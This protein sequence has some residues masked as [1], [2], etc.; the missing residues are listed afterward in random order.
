MCW[1]MLFASASLLSQS[2]K[3]AG[4]GLAIRYLWT[5]YQFPLDQTWSYLDFTYGAEAEF[6]Q[7][8]GARIDLGFPIRA[9]SALF[10]RGKT[11]GFEKG[12]LTSA[13]IQVQFKTAPSGARWVWFGYTGAGINLE[14]WERA[15]MAIP[16]G[17]GLDIRLSKN[18]FISS[19]I[20]YRFSQGDF[21]DHVQAAF[22]F[23]FVPSQKDRL[24]TIRAK[25]RHFRS[26]RDGDGVEDALDAC[27]DREGLAAL[28]G[29]PDIDG[30]GIPDD[31]DECPAVAGSLYGCPDADADGIA[32]K[33]DRCPLEVGPPERQGCPAKDTDQDGVLDEDDICPSQPG[34]ARTKGCPDADDDGIADKD[35]QCPALAGLPETRGCPD[36]DSDGVPDK[37][38]QC[39]NTPG[40][41]SGTGCPS[42]EASEIALLQQA[43]HAIHFISGPVLR[44]KPESFKTLDQI[45]DLM[46]KYPDFE[47][48]IAAFTDNAGEAETNRELSVQQAKFCYE[49]LISRGIG[50][51]RLSYAGHGEANPVGDNQTPEG[52]A[53]NR[54]MEFSIRPKQN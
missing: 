28:K 8:L 3:P 54:R 26:D 29:C 11:A 52:R 9:G 31:N 51:R 12:M 40:K 7:R 38:D 16:A 45:V 15:K 48:H 23:R 24:E 19:K 1:G 33:D 30:D 25:K 39:P 27:P 47:L 18:V 42:L 21:S 53:L 46:R 49:Y 14:D 2:S 32:D 10:P 5:N 17:G 4:G 36:T 37:E 50:P 13:D 34:P 35:D 41:G 6:R 43:S 44:L 22:G 20:E